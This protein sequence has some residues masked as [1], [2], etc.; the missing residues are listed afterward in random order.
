MFSRSDSVTTNTRT[1]A[2]RS[3][4][5]PARAIPLLLA[6]G[7]AVLALACSSGSADGT[8]PSG[9]LTG[10]CLFM[11]DSKVTSCYEFYGKDSVGN[12][13][14]QCDR[15][16][17]PEYGATTGVS[18]GKCPEEGKTFHDF[19]E[20]PD[21]DFRMDNFGYNTGSEVSADAGTK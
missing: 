2:Q 3:S 20:D 17:K 12:A 8:S 1:E 6:I 14:T 11:Q 15:F 18:T 4:F 9:E 21:R 7:F 16:H 10:S 5:W 13:K 19:I